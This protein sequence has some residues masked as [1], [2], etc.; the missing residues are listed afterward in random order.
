VST[1]GSALVALARERHPSRSRQRITL[2]L[3][4]I[5]A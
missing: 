4:A 5:G 3:G 1:V 2:K